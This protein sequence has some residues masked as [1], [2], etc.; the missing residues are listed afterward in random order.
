M[1]TARDILDLFEKNENR[2]DIRQRKNFLLHQK[3]FSNAYTEIIRSIDQQQIFSY[4][5]RTGM[6]YAYEQ[7]FNKLLNMDIVT[8]LDR[9]TILSL[10]KKTLV[11]TAIALD[12]HQVISKDTQHK[13]KY[14]YHIHQFMIKNIDE[15]S[16]SNSS[17]FYKKVRSYL[18]EEIKNLNFD[19]RVELSN[20]KSLIN[21]IRL[22]S[23][24]KSSTIKQAFSICQFD[25]PADIRRDNILKFNALLRSYLALNTLL[26]FEHVTSLTRH[27][28]T[29]YKQLINETQPQYITEINNYI[30]AHSNRVY[31]CITYTLEHINKRSESSIHELTHLA[32]D[33]LRNIIFN[34]SISYQQTLF[35]N[36]I[37]KIKHA[38]L[39][40][41]IESI[42][43]QY[44]NLIDIL[45]LI[46]DNQLEHALQEIKSISFDTLPFGFL[47]TAF[48]SIL[49]ALRIKLQKN[50]IKFGSLSD[51]INYGLINQ[52]PYCELT[53]APVEALRNEM[54]TNP[55][56]ITIIRA[57]QTYNNI[58]HHILGEEDLP[59]L[60]AHKQAADGF[61]IPVDTAINKLM[62]VF[63]DNKHK[64]NHQ[65]ANIIIK[66]KTLSKFELTGNLI[67]VLEQSTLYNCI[68]SMKILYKS[69]K[70]HYE[71]YHHLHKVIYFSTKKKMEIK[72][73]LEIIL[74]TQTLTHA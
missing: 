4:R 22:G 28:V 2:R 60:G 29:T 12:I 35:Y 48:A 40:N 50:K 53:T 3:Y 49:L 62:T 9:Y 42:P 19:E 55:N 11:P 44:I 65:I 30:Y 51:I 8:T 24:Q 27:V 67:S 56:N 47:T 16:E 72:R 10:Y 57:V 71:E 59:E 23:R 38:L 26:S 73:I 64:T 34:T 74:I 70:A 68:I 25:T 41:S 69:F 17:L 63:S 54:I 21:N 39:Y 6:L 37:E 36:D 15:L 66:E 5:F 14:Y 1:L 20:I 45:K 61:L 43:E 52:G 13:N 58:V 33:S 7:L 46:R 18:N 31:P 32:I